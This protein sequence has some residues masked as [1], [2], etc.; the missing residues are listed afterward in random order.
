MTWKISGRKRL[1]PNRNTSLQLSGGT[2]ES[3]AKSQSGYPVFRTWF[4][5]R[6]SWIRLQNIT[7]MG[8]RSVRL[9]TYTVSRLLLLVLLLL[10]LLLLLWL[11]WLLLGLGRSFSFLFLQTVGRT[12]LTG[13][14][15]L[16]DST[17]IINAYPCLQWHSN[18]RPQDWR[19]RKQFIP[20]STLPLW[21]RWLGES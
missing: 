16:K 15:R 19:G 13:S 6:T 3:H 1:R 2:E 4:E 10:L 8:T 9:V 7:A 12:P 20:Q 17:N 21:W 14:A 18:P 11:Y 5:T